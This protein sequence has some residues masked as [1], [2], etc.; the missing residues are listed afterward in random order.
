MKI[1]ITENQLNLLIES[2][3]DTI[4]PNS[5]PLFYHGSTDKKLNGKTGIHV[6][7]KLAAT[8]ALQAK[9]GVPAKGDW[10]GTREYGKTLLAGK[11]TL[12]K[13][14][15][16]L[17]YDPII[18][19]NATDD[20]PEEDYYPEDRKKRATFFSSSKLIPLDTR[21]VVFQ[22]LITGEMTNTPETPHTDEIANGLIS[23]Q[24]KLGNAKHGYYYK[25]KYEDEGSTSAVVPDK[26][27]LKIVK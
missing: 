4:K 26:T 8:Q 14:D 22:V 27:F 21:P 23:R 6:G 3:N 20:V 13:L 12:K 25:N 1:I 15:K 18:N 24:I 11:K 7:T 5:Y 16:K 2:I 9:I 17:K 19:F 10:D